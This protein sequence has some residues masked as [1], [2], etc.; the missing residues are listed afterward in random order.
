MGTV[1]IF[2]NGEQIPQS[3]VRVQIVNR[4]CDDDYP[5]QRRTSTS[6]GGCECDEGRMEISGRCVESTVMAVV[7]SITAVLLVALMG[8]CYL[9]YRNNKNDEMWQVSVEELQFDYPVEVIGQGSFGVVLL[10]QYRGTKVC[11]KRA[12]RLG[13]KGTNK[14]LRKGS[15]GQGTGRNN[16]DSM[17]MSSAESEPKS[18][19]QDPD[20][21]G[22]SPEEESGCSGESRSARDNQGGSRSHTASYNHNSLGFLA[23]DFGPS[24]KM[25]LAVPLAP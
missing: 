10:G 19:E 18:S 17:G 13:A 1:E 11:M 12:L 5:G 4:S 25:G 8:I 14:G 9:R 23:Q 6:D 21:G 16:T 3:P 22:I 2:I 24:S 15:K 7:I 20:E